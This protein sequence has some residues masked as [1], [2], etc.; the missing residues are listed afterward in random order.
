MLTLLYSPTNFASQK[1]NPQ[2]EDCL[3]LN[4]WSK[5]TGSTRKP[6]LIWFHGGRMVTLDSLG[7]ALISDIPMFVGFIGGSTNNPFYQG[8]Y[9]TDK[10]DVI[11]VT[12]NYR[13]NIFGF[14]GAPGL[15]Q[16]VGLLDQRLAVEW[17]RDNIAAFGGDPDRITIF[18]HS[19]GGVAVDYYTYAWKQDPI[20]SG[21]ISMAGTALS[22]AP[23]T[24]AE[25]TKYWNAAVTALGCQDSSDTVAC[26]RSKPFSE[27]SAAVLK[28]PPEPS[29]ALPQP[30]F[31]PT[32]DEKVV[33]SNYEELSARGEFAR[34][35]YLV[36]SGDYEAGYYKVSAHGAGKRL[37][38][39]QWNKFNLAAFTCSSARAAH[40]RATHG[41]PVWRYRYFGQWPNTALYP[42]S[43]A[44]HGT[45]VAQ[46]FGT[47]ADASGAP[48]TDAE[49]QVSSLMSHAWAAFAANPASGLSELGW[50]QYS[51]SGES[52]PHEHAPRCCDV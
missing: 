27:L 51:S 5:A 8:Q 44:Y 35:P 21:V 33:F 7:L 43:G 32:I 16:N 18:G 29:K 52:K 10:E 4:V 34:V 38:D 40:N 41:V 28:V 22:M 42:G 17:V 47:A 15:P 36:G 46:V 39:D 26:V 23:N 30:V 3:K 2:S 25:S 6:V 1:G 13:L 20:V 24:P 11:I 49:N 19:A 48:N 14:A 50:P 9:M 12:V 31:H 37:T 45:D